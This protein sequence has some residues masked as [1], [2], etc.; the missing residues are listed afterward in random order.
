MREVGGDMLMGISRNKIA[1]KEESD[2]KK[3][4]DEEDG[5]IRGELSYVDCSD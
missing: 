1:R 3:A 4:E 5:N 2:E